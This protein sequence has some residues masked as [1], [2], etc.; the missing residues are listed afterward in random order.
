MGHECHRCGGALSSADSFCPHCG[1][2]QFRYE[3]PGDGAAPGE[4]ARTSS[5]HQGINWKQAI[6][7]A[8]TFAVPVGLLSS[9][10]VPLLA[11][12]CCLW[13]VGG[14]IAAVALYRRRSREAAVNI[15]EG[16]LIGATIGILA[17]FLASA[18][19]GAL[20]LVQRY[21]MHGGA[22]MEKAFQTSME[23]GSVFAG[24]LYQVSPDQ[25]AKAMQFWLSPDGRAAAVLLTA[26]MA[27][28]GIIFFSA[29]GGALGARIFS[30]RRP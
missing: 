9:S 7:A 1:A 25:A 15:R 26:F 30:S 29:V 16:L 13:V 14:A 12:A 4:L 11:D 19:N 2:P 10:A 18:L 21:A 23:Q 6:G 8:V 17:A 27:S 20:M 24:Q 3:K 5:P 28:T 22:A